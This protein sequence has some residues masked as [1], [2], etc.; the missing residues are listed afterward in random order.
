MKF[1]YCPKCG[2]LQTRNWHN[3]K[4]CPL[5]HEDAT[6]ISVKP[7]PFGIMMWATSIIAMVFVALYVMETDLGFGTGSYTTL[8]LF[9]L[10]VSFVSGFFE[11]GR[12]EKLARA[13][14]RDKKVK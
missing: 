8:I 12:A 13:Q 11:I 9:F 10:I 6:I 7:G 4:R 1:L 14:I 2:T 5:C 3:W